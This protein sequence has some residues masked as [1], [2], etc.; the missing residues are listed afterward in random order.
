MISYKHEVFI[1][2]ARLLSFTKASQTLFISQSAISKQIQA[3]ESFY[4]TG[5]FERKGNSIHLTP[6]GKLLYERLLE[7]RQFQQTLFQDMQ[8][9]NEAFAPP[10]RM[11]LGASTTISLY[12]L[13]RVLSAYLQ[14]HPSLQ[15]TLKNRNSENILKALLDHE[16]DL[17]IVE[18]VSKANNVTSIPFLTDDVIAVCSP[19]S[20]LKDQTLTIA[21]LR[22]TPIALRETGSGTLAVVEEALAATG[23]DLSE[24]PVRVR[25]GGTEALKNFVRVDTA[26]A[27]LPRQAVAK[28]LE[29]GELI[30]LHINGLQITRT[31]HFIQRRGTENQQALQDFIRFTKRYYAKPA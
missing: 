10:L 22:Q 28:E 27:F 21:D 30:Q 16:I 17:G 7:A 2:V 1:E 11:I 8:A 6:A 19:T 12:V 13:P 25:L 5:L 18:A 14:Q 9:L 15:L 23:I 26:M 29:S 3:L 4:K 20:P 31:F 24:L